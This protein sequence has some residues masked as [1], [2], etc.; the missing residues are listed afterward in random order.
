[1]KKLRKT[2]PPPAAESGEFKYLFLISTITTAT[3]SGIL[4]RRAAGTEDLFVSTL[5]TPPGASG[6]VSTF[7]CFP[8]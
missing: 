4:R 2:R 6:G 3:A 7:F 1:V 8:T 5:K